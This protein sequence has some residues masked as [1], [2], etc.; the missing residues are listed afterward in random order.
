LTKVTGNCKILKVKDRNIKTELQQ[1]QTSLK[2]ISMQQ[3]KD[4][5]AMIDNLKLRRI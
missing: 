1:G 5:D 4:G 3:L 2:V